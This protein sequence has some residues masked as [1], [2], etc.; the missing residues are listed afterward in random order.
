[1]FQQGPILVVPHLVDR[2]VQLVVRGTV[3]GLSEDAQGAFHMPA[4]AHGPTQ[5]S[6]ERHG[7]GQLVEG[8]MT[9]HAEA[10][11]NLARLL[12]LR[13]LLTSSLID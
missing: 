9:D 6:K 1:M 5:R 4:S 13:H 10:S 12:R 7:L 2:F 3:P 11:R 8:G